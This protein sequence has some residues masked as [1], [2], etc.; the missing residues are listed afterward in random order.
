MSETER[1]W[2]IRNPPEHRH[3][4]ATCDVRTLP[5]AL[6]KGD[7]EVVPAEQLR[8]AVDLLVIADAMAVAVLN[9]DDARAV[10]EGYRAGRIAAASAAI[11]AS[12][13]I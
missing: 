1:R 7:V 12:S 11:S 5:F 3:E 10:A 9:G 8:G 4:R 2:A 6:Y 13:V